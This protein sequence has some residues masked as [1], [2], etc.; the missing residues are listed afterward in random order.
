MEVAEGRVEA[1][2]AQFGYAAVAFGVAVEGEIV[3]LTAAY[4]AEQGV[5]EPVL[6]A[7]SAFAGSL[8]VYHTCFWAGRRHGRAILARRPAWQ[9]RVVS[10]QQRIERH[11][12]PLILGYRL[13]FG[14]RAATPFALGASGVSH[15]RFLLLDTP[16]AVIWAAG[17]VAAGY[18]LGRTVRVLAGEVEVVAGWAGATVLVLV[19]AVALAWRELGRRR[20]RRRVVG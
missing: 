19:L 9:A 1:L 10:L 5:L 11:D 4:L 14:L 6:V 12:L 18:A 3:V 13:L 20:A 16:V 8:G 15:R 7:L 2:I 17:L